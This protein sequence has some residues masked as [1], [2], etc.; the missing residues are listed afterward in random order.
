M[1]LLAREADGRPAL[2]GLSGRLRR[3]TVALVGPGALHSVRSHYADIAFLA[4]GL[5]TG[6]TALADGD[7]EEAAVKRAM[8]EQAERV[9][10]LAAAPP[11]PGS[12]P[13]VALAR[14]SLALAGEAADAAALRAAGVAVQ[15]PGGSDPYGAPDQI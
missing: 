3:E 12:H 4:A 6:G 15:V 9:V 2:V 11:A 1:Q 10:L 8:C 13:V 5:E 7:E 14:V